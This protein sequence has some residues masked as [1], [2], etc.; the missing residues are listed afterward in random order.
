MR[1]TA[2]AAA[3]LS[4]CALPDAE[5]NVDWQA[6]FVLDRLVEWQIS[7]APE[8]WQE[9]THGRP[10]EYVPAELVV[11]GFSYGTVGMRLTG[12]PNR[13]KTGF[14][15]RF[16]EYNPALRFHGAKRVNL[17]ASAGDP[18]LLREAMAL[19]LMRA[20]GVPAPR[21][22]LVWVSWGT[23]GGVY[24][25]VQQIDKRFLEDQFGEDKGDLYKIGLGGNLVYSGDDT[26]S[27]DWVAT[28]ML[29]TNELDANHRGLVQL[30]KALS[31]SDPETALPRVLDVD[32]AL[33]M[34]AVDSW[35][36]N[37]SS[38]AGTGGHTYLYQTESGRF[39]TIPWGLNRAFGNFH[40][41]HC[42]TAAGEEECAELSRG[43]WL[44]RQP[45]SP[46]YYVER[47]VESCVEHPAEFCRLI[48]SADSCEPQPVY[49]EPCV[50]STD[51]LLSLDP[52]NPTCSVDRPLVT[53]LLSVPSWADQYR[54]RLQ[55]LL[56]GP[57]APDQIESLALSMAARIAESAVDDV[58]RDPAYASD[59]TAIPLMSTLYE[60]STD[61]PEPSLHDWAERTPGLLTFAEDRD[62]TIRQI[63]GEWQ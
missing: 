17:R 42:A 58:G 44:S 4:S 57:L 62:A 1:R 60:D 22:S 46:G 7:V 36:A 51:E 59:G 32:E 12:N 5:G 56:D 25:L 3:L 8:D 27:Y 26:E 61:E 10:T 15:I 34:L 45:E 43:H 55:S 54:D 11:D 19:S 16:N 14:R 63:L 49:C 23:G 9:L 40:G 47:G 20:A 53:A 30:M 2:L 35:L 28:Y 29:K 33:N 6:I 50:Y 24:T 38:Y 41:A 13:A 31:A 21:S 39:R 52:F 37:M 48:Q 18:S